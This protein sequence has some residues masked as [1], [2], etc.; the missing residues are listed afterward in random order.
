MKIL[1]GGA[2]LGLNYGAT[3]TAG[4]PGEAALSA[5]LSEAE[6]R[7]LIGIDTAPAYG[8][9]EERL[10]QYFR[11]HKNS[12]LRVETKITPF[13]E[14]RDW[15]GRAVAGLERSA[16]RLGDRIDTLLF[17]SPDPLLSASGDGIWKLIANARNTHLPNARLGVSVYDA[18]TAITLMDRFP[19]QA[20][21][22]PLNPLDQRPLASGALK[23]LASSGVEITV[24]SLFLQGVLLAR[25]SAG[26]PAPVAKAWPLV[27]S[28]QSLA[29]RKFGSPQL[30][31]FSFL[32]ALANDGLAHR[33]VVGAA[34]AS[35]LS[36]IMT[37][38]AEATTGALEDFS[39]L[40]G[41][42]DLLL[43]PRRWGG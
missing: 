20:V 35:E 15:E 3:N 13:D 14:K 38:Y 28:F 7:S 11:L 18:E 36:E 41:A 19:V 29:T 1:L 22:L 4:R 23:R 9:S 30:A 43:D 39:E 10:G 34:N 42:P 40:K 12:S 37:A 33:A 26:L 31:C 16:T 5:L 27:E 24:R 6:K 25:E 32:K 17:H 8:D 2:Q 21:Q